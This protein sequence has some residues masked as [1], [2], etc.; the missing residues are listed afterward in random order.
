LVLVEYD[1]LGIWGV[2]LSAK[3]ANFAFSGL[4]AATILFAGSLALAGGQQSSDQN[5]AQTT[6]GNQSAAPGANGSQVSAAGSQI[7]VATRM[8]QVGVIVR[9][10]NGA[11]TK[12]TKD[13]F[14]IFDRGKEQKISLF[15]P[16]S[17]Q[18][19][20]QTAA[21]KNAQP[22][23]PNVF[24]DLPQQ[25][26]PVG[27]VT[28]IL[29]D[30]LNTLT[31]GATPYES[32]PLWVEDHALANAR[33]HLIEFIATMNPN[34]RVAIYGLRDSLHVLCDFTSDRE[35]L[36]KILKNYDPSSLTHREAAEPAAIHTPVPGDF[37]PLVNRDRLNLA[38]IVNED[39]SQTT[40]AALAAIS[41][42]VANIPGRKNLVWLTANLPLSAGAVAAVLSRAQIAAY[43][44][45]GRGLLARASPVTE[46]DENDFDKMTRR[47]ASMPAQ[48]AQPI[49]I[50]TMLKIAELTGGKA[51]V[52]TN[53][54]TGAVRTAVEDSG[55]TYTLGFYIDADAIDGKFHELKVIAKQRR[56][57]LRYPQGYFA[58]KDQGASADEAHKNMVS[59]VDSPIEA[60][61]IPVEARID[62]VNKPTP[63]S[64]DVY[65]AIDIHALRFVK[66][67][68][69]QT[70]T[71]VIS[72]LQQDQTGKV[73]NQAVEKYPLRLSPEEYADGLK[74]G[75]RFRQ[76][77]EQQAGTTTLRVL[78]EDPSTA[79]V[80]S[81]IIPIAQIK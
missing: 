8:V 22:L 14:S 19:Q 57:T 39:R 27:S 18:L 43:P 47:G 12:L 71:V 37:D 9:D 32:T 6:N 30:N 52:N 35:E 79:M 34:D 76:P 33:A 72:V 66:D 67:G 5:Q 70:G 51:F 31:G 74:S 10:K 38:G 25:N 81:L 56:L 65:G 45:D 73:L 1:W 26:A 58:L 77:V 63:N 64:I 21:L 78:V 44:V 36:L 48:T 24:T 41:G 50:D 4:A 16:E 17:A 2:L 20:E 55:V 80:G 11:A 3:P 42:H 69:V 29:L 23:P 61:G 40:M 60:S 13:D 54:L 49:G 15:V 46:E 28:I 53:D 75:I 62:R 7:R 59:A 68:E